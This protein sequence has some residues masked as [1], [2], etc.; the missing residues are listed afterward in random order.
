MHNYYEK[1]YTNGWYGLY[2]I[3][4]I[5]CI[6]YIIRCCGLGTAFAYK[7]GDVM[8]A[9]DT[10]NHAYRV[11]QDYLRINPHIILLYIV[12]LYFL[13]HNILFVTLYQQNK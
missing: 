3:L 2:A 1:H 13:T 9:T 8:L 10:A 6:L 7:E 11:I 4:V 12:V 5:H